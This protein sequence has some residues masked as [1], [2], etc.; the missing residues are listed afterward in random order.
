MSYRGPPAAQ[1]RSHVRYH[2]DAWDR[3]RNSPQDLCRGRIHDEP[4]LDA[5]LIV[6]CCVP[7][8]SRSGH[9]YYHLLRMDPGSFVHRHE[10][11]FDAAMTACQVC[12]ECEA[13]YKCPACSLQTCSLPCV[14]KHKKEQRCSGKRPRSDYVKITEFKDDTLHR[15]M[16]YC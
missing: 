10:K 6:N 11:K 1:M 8:A 16:F 4:I 15:G 3:K 7:S 5:D 12:G 14:S 13:K 2:M 9:G